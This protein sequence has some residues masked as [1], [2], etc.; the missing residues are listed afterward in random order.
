MAKT[1]WD[2]VT[3]IVIAL[4]IAIF[5]NAFVFQ[6]MVVAGPSMEPTL[7]DGEYLL[8]QKVTHTFDQLPAYGDVVVI[9]SRIQ[10]ERSVTDDLVEPI[11]KWL[12]KSDYVY[13]KR[14]VGRPGD[15]LEFNNGSVYRNGQLLNETY[16][17]EEDRHYADK[18]VTVP[19]GHI[20]VMGDNRNNSLDS[21]W[22]GSIPLNHCLGNVFGKL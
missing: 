8:V 14:V 1:I 7:K 4:A 11:G 21:R 18:T 3:S 19:P 2:W 10:R 6:R 16:V 17:K 15:T 13:V 20:F 5:I 12:N 9:D 22:L